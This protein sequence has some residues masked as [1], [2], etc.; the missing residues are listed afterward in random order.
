MD[1]EILELETE[2]EGTIANVFQD[3]I[4]DSSISTEGIESTEESTM[5]HMEDTEMTYSEVVE[6][7]EPV[8]DD[9]TFGVSLLFVV[10]MLVGIFVFHIFSRRWQS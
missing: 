8:L 3:D 6:E 5:D 10:S 2:T 9:V 1:E 4:S 7:Q